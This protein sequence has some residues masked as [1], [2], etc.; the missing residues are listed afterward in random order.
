MSLK[1]VDSHTCGQPTRVILDGLPDIG[2][3]SAAQARELLRGQHDAIRR[4]AVFEPRGYPALLAVASFPPSSRAEHW[5]VVFMDATGYPDMCGHATIGVATT[6]VET[7]RLQAAANGGSSVMLDTPGGLVSLELR[8]IDGRV[9]S[10]KLINR[11]A[12]YLETVPVSGPNGRMTLPIAY[13]GQWYAFADAVAV[14]LKV[15]PG[16]VAELVR[17]AASLR[18]LV[19][20][21]VSQPDPRT[22]RPP[23]VEN[24]MWT[25]DP[26]DSWVDG[27]NMPVNRAGAFDRSP[28]GTGTSARLAVLHATGELAVGEEYV[29]SGV[30]GTVYRARIAHTTQVAGH[31]AVVPEITG[32]AWLTAHAELWC[33]RT[34]PLAS[35]FLL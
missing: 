4:L 8:V 23:R 20:E 35:G 24:I 18:P 15:E 3:S 32:S 7:G 13:G 6:L 17:V 22:E 26:V 11:P 9:D 5:R 28:C 29:N 1:V 12:Y 31:E 34:D 30:L 16:C 14:G 19:A 27:R 21:A 33:D 10:V 25:D 2:D